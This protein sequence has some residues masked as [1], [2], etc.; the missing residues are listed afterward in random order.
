MSAPETK[1]NC[2]F[3]GCVLNAHYMVLHPD[4]EVRY[5]GYAC[6][7]HAR[8][9][10]YRPFRLVPLHP[11]GPAEPSAAEEPRSAKQSLVI[12]SSGGEHLRVVVLKRT[13]PEADGFWERNWLDCAIDVSAGGFQGSVNANLRAEDLLG[14]RDALDMLRDGRVREAIFETT[15]QWLTMQVTVAG[16][17]KFQAECELRDDPKGNRLYFVMAFSTDGMA[18]VLE[19]LDG[20]VEAFPVIGRSLA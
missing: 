16:E 12:G 18:S 19:A 3:T 8:E 2:T 20:I 1:A 7:K 15:Q 9:H 11:I 5:V 6:Y 13:R 10:D 4:P 17:G 14:F